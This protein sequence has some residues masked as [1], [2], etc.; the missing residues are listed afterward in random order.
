M[1]APTNM[2]M[3]KDILSPSY[4]HETFNGYE[5][6]FDGKYEIIVE[7]NRN[8]IVLDQKNNKMYSDLKFAHSALAN[9]K[10]LP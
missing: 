7:N 4:K 5:K 10:K 8:I 1:I 2:N 9:L 3:I 6:F